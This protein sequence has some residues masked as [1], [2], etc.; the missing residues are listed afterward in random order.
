[1]RRVAVTE[2]DDV[3][4]PTVSKDPFL[5]LATGAI[6]CVGKEQATEVAEV[7]S[8]YSQLA[9]CTEQSASWKLMRPQL[10]KKFPTFHRNRRFITVSTKPATGPYREPHNPVH[11]L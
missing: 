2:L 6:L 7:A 9:N 4:T 11:T 1:M 10:V 8:S 3:T 5:S